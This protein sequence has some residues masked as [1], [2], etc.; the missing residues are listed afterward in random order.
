MG[1][2]FG[3][4]IMKQGVGFDALVAL[5]VGTVLLVTLPTAMAQGSNSERGFALASSPEAIEKNGSYYAL[6]V[7]IN[8]YRH[9]PK[10]QTAVNDA[11]SVAKILQDQ[12]GF[13][14]RKLQNDDATR[15]NI[16]DMLSSYRSLH[17]NDNLLIY[18]AGHGMFDRETGTTYWMPVDAEPDRPSHSISA[19]EIKISAR[20]IPARHILF[21]SDSCYSGGI[22]RDVSSTERTGNP[23]KFLQRML[24]GKSRSVMA[25]GNVEPVADS[26]AQGHS[27][28]ANAVLGG[29]TAMVTSPFTAR[30]LFDRYIQRP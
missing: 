20:G 21:V 24:S 2:D 15:S 5:G 23:D 12:Y 28:F 17:E 25:S 1:A 27:V 8:Q 26:G 30:D 11:E 3:A 29:L 16:L 14:V 9:L 18:Y 13:Q 10:L 19:D 4:E 7:G 6:V 22:T